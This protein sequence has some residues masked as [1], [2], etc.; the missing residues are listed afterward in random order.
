MSRVCRFFSS[1]NQDTQSNKQT[2]IMAAA[3]GKDA[4]LD[5]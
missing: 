4:Q 5:P 1:E 2:Q 3:D